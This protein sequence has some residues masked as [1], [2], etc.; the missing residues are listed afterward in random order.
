MPAEHP[1][2]LP[3]DEPVERTAVYLP[4]SWWT[5]LMALGMAD[6]AS[7]SAQIAVLV[8]RHLDASPAQQAKVI[9]D[10]ARITR[11]RRGDNVRRSDR[12]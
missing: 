11:G 12:A 8:R 1:V 4:R 3:D 2:Q 9:R 10:A 6:K 7:A 5:Q